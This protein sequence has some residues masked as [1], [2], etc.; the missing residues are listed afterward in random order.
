MIAH[1]RNRHVVPVVMILTLLCTVTSMCA[2]LPSARVFDFE[3]GRLVMR[4]SPKETAEAKASLE[5]VSSGNI[6][7]NL[8]GSVVF[9][10]E[11]ISRLA[12]DRFGQPA[13]MMRP[14]RVYVG[15][16]QLASKDITIVSPTIQDGG[17]VLE[18]HKKYRILAVDFG[19]RLFTW[20]A[21][22]LELIDRRR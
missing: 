12:D 8:E 2:A 22:V 4:N 17:V 13:W 9:D 16:N 1:R 5:K 14:D 10:G 18:R 3:D 15:A 6:E 21:A 11:V 7:R 19:G 20:N